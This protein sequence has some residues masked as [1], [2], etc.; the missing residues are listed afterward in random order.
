MTNNSHNTVYNSRIAIIFLRGI[1]I[2]SRRLF[3]AALLMIAAWLTVTQAL[4]ADWTTPETQLAGK[5]AAVTGPGAVVLDIT[6]R[7][8]LTPADFDEISRGLRNQLAT[9]GLQFVSADQ[10]AATIQIS[11]SENQQEQ[12]L[13]GR[14]PPGNERA[15]HSN[16]LH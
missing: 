3:R 15:L 11:L 9:L 7:S 12:R 2:P 14:D 5:I 6:N 13:G 4:A 1:L 8:S 16:G 10:A